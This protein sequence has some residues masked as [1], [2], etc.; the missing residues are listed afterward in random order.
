MTMQTLE[1][2]QLTTPARPSTFAKLEKL[3]NPR[4]LKR[5]IQYLFVGGSS[6]LVDF[7]VLTALK[8]FFN[9]PTLEANIISYSCGTINSFLL[10]HFWVYPESR[11][12]QSFTRLCQY[13][14]ISLIGLVLNN[15]IVLGLEIPFGKLLHNA[16]YGFLPAKII[17]TGLV[18]FWNF[19]ANRLWTFGD[20]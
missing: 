1:P 13:V 16:Q 5:L 14:L 3:K 6:T 12:R 10:S 7:L 18:L 4:E 8:F 20:V 17:A 15:L 19:L 9:M 11:H 2:S